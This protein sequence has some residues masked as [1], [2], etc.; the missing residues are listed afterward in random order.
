MLGESDTWHH[1]VHPPIEIQ[2]LLLEQNLATTL[3]VT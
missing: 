1:C 3:V 2:L